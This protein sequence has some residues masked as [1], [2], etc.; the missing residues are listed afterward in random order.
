MMIELSNQQVKVLHEAL[1]ES[2]GIAKVYR[3]TVADEDSIILM[4][5]LRAIARVLDMEE[6]K[7]DEPGHPS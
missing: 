4:Q 6:P 3:E 1:H 5:D 2:I 7:T